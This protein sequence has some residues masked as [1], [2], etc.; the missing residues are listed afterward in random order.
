MTYGSKNENFLVDIW[1]IMCL[2]FRV[3]TSL[4]AHVGDEHLRWTKSYNS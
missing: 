3:S 4:P 1:A 2:N